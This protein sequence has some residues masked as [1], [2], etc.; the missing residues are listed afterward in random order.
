MARECLSNK[1]LTSAKWTL[2]S[3][4]E[5]L[6]SDKEIYEFTE[7]RVSQNAENSTVTPSILGNG[8]QDD[9]SSLYTT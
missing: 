1:T 2:F 5:F 7:L 4:L 9:I 8:E 6:I 3:L